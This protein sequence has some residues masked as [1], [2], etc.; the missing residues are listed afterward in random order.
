LRDEVVGFL[1]LHHEVVVGEHVLL[2][3]LNWELDKHTGDL[4]HSLV[5]YE[6]LDEWEDSL[7]NSLF[8]VRVLL[9]DLGGDLHS[10]LLVLGGNWVGWGCSWGS[11]LWHGGTHWGSWL[12]WHHVALRHWWSHWASWSWHTTS[13]WHWLAIWHHLWWLVHLSTWASLLS[14][15]SW[16]SVVLSWSSVLRSTHHVS[17]LLI[18]VSIHGL[19]LLHDVQQLLENLSHMRVASE[20]IE[21]EGSSL[22]SLILLKVSLINGIFDLDFSLL[23]DL[24]VVDDQCLSFEGSVV[25]VGLGNSS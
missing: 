12:W 19:I 8:Q 21:V 9:G 14:I 5:S 17:L 10:H 22:L 24:V 13:H 15:A 2:D 18:E 4:W 25:K 11:R 6:V 20:V 16:T 1:N 23:L 3:L 7:T